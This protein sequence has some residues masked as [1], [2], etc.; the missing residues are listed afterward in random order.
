MRAEPAVQ[1][2]IHFPPAPRETSGG[3]DIFFT[4]VGSQRLNLL[5]LVDEA[6]PGPVWRTRV[7][8]AQNREGS[9]SILRPIKAVRKDHR[10]PS[11]CRPDRCC[12]VAETGSRRRTVG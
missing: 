2:S 5:R 1:R 12:P 3:N 8:E 9:D 4:T 11:L 7:L 6:L 10:R